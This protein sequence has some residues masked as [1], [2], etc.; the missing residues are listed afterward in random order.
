[1]RVC[2]VVLCSFLAALIPGA[3]ASAAAT[4]DGPTHVHGIQSGDFVLPAGTVCDFPLHEIF[5]EYDNDI[6]FGDP[7]NPT[8]IRRHVTS[9]ITHINEATGYTL[10]EVLHF[11]A[12]LDLTTGLVTQVGVFWHLRDPSGKLV[13]VQAGRLVYSNETGEIISFTPDI[14][15]NGAEVICTAL[16]GHPAG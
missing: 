1:M 4:E 2:A 6:V 13:V 16:G 5:T 10:T 7:E 9:V 3:R 15:P 12:P 14:N 8:L 11:S